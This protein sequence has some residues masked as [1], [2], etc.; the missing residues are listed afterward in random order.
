MNERIPVLIVSGFL[1]SGKT[2]L[3]R[4]LLADAQRTGVRLA[5][6]SNEFGELGVDATLFTAA[7]ED[8]V[9]LSGGCICCK[10]SDALVETLQEI[11]ER[12]NPDRIVI[13]T[14]GVAL[15][16][17]TQLQ[18]WRDPVRDWVSDDVAVV[19]VNAEQVATGRDLDD[20]FEQQ[21][22][23]ADLLLLNQVDQV[24]EDALPRLEDTLRELEPEAPILRA[25]HARVAP[26]L[27]F[28]PDPEGLRQRRRADGESAAPHTH[29]PFASEELAVPDG[30]SEAALLERLSNLGAL[31]AKG[32]V[33][34]DAGLRVV[35]GV[36][37]RVQLEVPDF[38]VPAEQRGRIVVIRRAGSAAVPH[39]SPAA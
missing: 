35:Q 2:T 26:D 23:S 22:S 29:E 19:V 20:T 17:D 9:E 31:R 16:F 33:V 25:N 21:V 32:F 18:L 8:Y 5:V 6:V 3:V 15:P 24:P 37:A 11:R 39:G 34:T 30:I 36:G 27:L 38:E 4:H 13:E 28:P 7:R 1:G 12:S 10:L 14:S